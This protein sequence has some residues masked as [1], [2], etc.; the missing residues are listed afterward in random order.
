[1]RELNSKQYVYGNKDYWWYNITS[2]SN[3]DPTEVVVLNLWDTE[4]RNLVK[5][6]VMAMNENWLLR[7]NKASTHFNRGTE[8]CKIHIQRHHITG[9]FIIYFGRIEDGTYSLK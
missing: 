6:V 8:I 1:M 5:R 3:L 9:K 7:I 4:N 2:P